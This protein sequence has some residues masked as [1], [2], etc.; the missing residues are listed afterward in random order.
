MRP[1]YFVLKEKKRRLYLLFNT[2][3]KGI[4]GGP[5]ESCI[6][7]TKQEIK[8]GNRGKLSK[9]REKIITFT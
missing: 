3:F 7:Y 4:R 1:N 8:Y 5:C 6:I 9:N 2:V